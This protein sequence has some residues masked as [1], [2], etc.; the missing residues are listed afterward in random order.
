MTASPSHFAARRTDAT[1]TGTLPALVRMTRPTQ[2][3]LVALVYLNGALLAT[4]RVG[5]VAIDTH[6]LGL[7]LVLLAAVAAHLA[8][9][10][11]D[12]ETDRLSRRTRYSGGSGALEASGLRPRVPLSIALVTSALVVVATALATVEGRLTSIAAAVLLL[13]L[14]GSLSYS[15]PPLAFMRRG[16][17]E[18]LNA[19]LG[20]LLLPLFGVAIVAGAIG[21]LDFLAFLPFLFIVL[22]SVMATAWPDREADAAT[23]KRTLQVRLPAAKLRRIH[24]GA[25]VAFVVAIVASA[26]FDAM[27]LALAGLLVLPAVVLGVARYTRGRSPSPNVAAMVGLALVTTTVL[28]LAVSA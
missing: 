21:V 1:R 5:A 28:A 6:A 26:W 12:H 10:A 9:E 18:P 17:G 24:A 27:P 4:W 19:L 15:L 23:G 11:A 7:A 8:N 16:L 13:G 14:V 3:A 20:G 22:A 2:L 25:S